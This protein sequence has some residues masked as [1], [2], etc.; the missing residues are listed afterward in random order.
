MYRRVQLVYI[1]V[2][3]YSLYTL[4]YRRVQLVYIDVQESSACIH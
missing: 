3:E 2:Q 4:L 1:D